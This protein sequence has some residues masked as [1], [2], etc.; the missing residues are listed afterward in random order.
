MVKLRNLT[1]FGLTS[2]VCELLPSDHVRYAENPA[3]PDVVRS[4]ASRTLKT[5][6][7]R[8]YASRTVE[9]PVARR[10]IRACLEKDIPVILRSSGLRYA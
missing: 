1:E 6:P 8:S 3:G 2:I 5:R 7:V 10:G 9:N 4:C